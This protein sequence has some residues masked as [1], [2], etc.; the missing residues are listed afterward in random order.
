MISRLLARRQLRDP[1][2]AFLFD[3]NDGDEVVAFDTE[4][5]S[6][7]VATA[8]ILSIGAVR[9]CGN[10]IY[11][12]EALELLLKP[13]GIISADS[14]KI[15]H[16][17]HVDLQHGLE[18][19]VA[20]GRFLEFIGARPLVGYFLQIDI[21]MIE[22]Y[23]RPWLGI[24]LPNRQIEISGLY[25]QYVSSR[26]PERAVDLRFESL[27]RDLELPLFEVHNARSDA[28][29]TAMAYIKLKAERPRRWIAQRR[30][31]FGY[32]GT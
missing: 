20:I 18:P 6:L 5:T 23:L 10:R 29:M 21:A 4:V 26:H 2:Y 31:P 22:K 11:A 9:L 13:Q 16:L 1:T 8:E 17:R 32:I 12:G 27:V 30:V 15:H 3:G 28:I 19:R 7:N 25:H 24:G 14:I